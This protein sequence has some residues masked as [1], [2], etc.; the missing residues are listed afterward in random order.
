[1]SERVCLTRSRLRGHNLL[2]VIIA[3]M[4]FCTAIL[5][6]L[7]VW[8]SFYSA[9]SLGRNRLAAASLARAVLEQKIAAGFYACEPPAS[10]PLN[11][12]VDQGEVN[13]ISEIRGKSIDCNF[14]YLFYTADNAPAPDNTFRK[15]TVKVIWSDYA[16]GDKTLTYETHLYR[17]N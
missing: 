17:T 16:G 14:R 15:L 11:T 9:Q 8:S 12:P 5:L 6:F 4:I 10:D 13:S 2:E 7:G 1:V 3:S